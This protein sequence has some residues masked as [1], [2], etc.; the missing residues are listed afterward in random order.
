VLCGVFLFRRTFDPKLETLNLFGGSPSVGL[1]P[2]F[3]TPCGLIL[4]IFSNLKTFG[5]SSK[6]EFD[7]MHSFYSLSN[8]RNCIDIKCKV[9]GSM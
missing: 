2:T 8:A 3:S 7:S 5:L 9:L 4:A 1:S 6:F